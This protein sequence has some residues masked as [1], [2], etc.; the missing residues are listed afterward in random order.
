MED[1]D[2]LSIILSSNPGQ[3]N[4]TRSISP[5]SSRYNHDRE[6]NTMGFEI[7]PWFRCW[8]AFEGG[9]VLWVRFA[10][11]CE[12]LN[13]KLGFFGVLFTGCLLRLR[14]RLHVL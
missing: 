3:T 4:S 14:S 13:T 10:K 2:F 12:V 1:Q 5:S 9:R 6:G 7:E 11:R 8:C